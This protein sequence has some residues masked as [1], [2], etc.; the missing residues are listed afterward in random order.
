MNAYASI[1]KREFN[2]E[3]AIEIISSILSELSIL[4]LNYNF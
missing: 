2:Y 1:Y 3:K 4:N